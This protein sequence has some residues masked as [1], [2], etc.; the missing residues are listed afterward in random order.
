M[1]T[2]PSLLLSMCLNKR[3]SCCWCNVGVNGSSTYL[4]FIKCPLLHD[5]T[6]YLDSCSSIK[7]ATSPPCD[8]KFVSIMGQTHKLPLEV[9]EI[10]KM[11]RHLAQSSRWNELLF[12]S[13][14]V[15]S[16]STVVGRSTVH[17]LRRRARSIEASP[18]LKKKS[19]ISTPETTQSQLPQVSR[20]YWEGASN[21][22]CL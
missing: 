10:L 4:S 15:V 8:D 9:G 13:S 12:V 19:I 7:N 1:H 11:V 5:T 14:T 20:R 22:T 18:F 16:Y 17:P 6:S 21:A 2:V 3:G